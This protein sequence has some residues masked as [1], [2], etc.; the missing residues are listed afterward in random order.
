[1]TR[2]V[3]S[4]FWLCAAS[5]ALSLGWLLPNNSPPWLSF[6]KDAWIGLILA[7]VS[8][9]VL[10]P[11]LVRSQVQVLTL[12]VAVFSLIPMIQHVTGM[13][14][15]F[16][17]AW[18]Q[19]LYL[20]GFAL[21]LQTGA[22]WEK[23]TKGQ[24]ADFVFLALGVGALVSCG[25]AFYQWLGLRTGMSE[26]ILNSVISNRYYANLAQPNLLGSL[27]LLGVIASAWA[28]WRQKIRGWLA[29]SIAVVLLFGVVLTGSRTAWLNIMI[30]VVGATLCRSKLPHQSY[31]RAIFGLAIA[32]VL[33]VVSLPSINTFLGISEDQIPL[34]FRSLKDVR[35]EAWV[36]LFDAALERPWVGFGW[37]QVG[38]ANFSVLGRYPEQSA[39]FAH[40]HNLILDLILWNG[41]PIGLSVSALLGFLLLVLL[42]RNLG[43]E[44]IILTAM[45]SILA[46]HA[47]LEF[48]LQYAYFLLPLGL[49][50]GSLSTSLSFRPVFEMSPIVNLLVWSI[51]VLAMA[52]TVLDYFKAETS[53]YGLRFEDRGIQTTIPKTP[54]E[55]L[56]LTQ[57]HE[58][59]KLARNVPRAGVSQDELRAMRNIVLV[60]PSALTIQ[61]LA[62][63]LALNGHEKE[64]VEWLRK[65]CKTTVPVVCQMMERRWSILAESNPGLLRAPW[66]VEFR[67][68]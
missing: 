9:W 56:V 51:A 49:V 59:I 34:E 3:V 46:T 60:M 57:F 40:S 36:M 12:V 8:F 41:F 28:H 18:M 61:K 1:M 33:F 15:V 45:V 53:M 64:A 43:F 10:W 25:I 62:A 24:A 55:V 19:S 11:R 67:S 26:W 39:I 65:G 54:P 32:T 14:P 47:L 5:L 2:Q 16:G 66:P 30:L 31:L 50:L 23:L 52:I 58:S 35:L 20:L 37:G 48:P 21:A 63:N 29:W 13:V 42:R 27:L 68:K 38:A 6:H 4:W 7:I 44:Q 17:V 22:T